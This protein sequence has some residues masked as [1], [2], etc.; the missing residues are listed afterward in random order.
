MP[1]HAVEVLGA[2]EAKAAPG[3]RQVIP[4]AYVVLIPP[5]NPVVSVGPII[6]IPAIRDALRSTAAP[7]VGVSPIL[8]G[9]AVRGM[10]N[11][12]LGGL[13][14]EVSASGVAGFHGG[15]AAEG[16]LDGWLIDHSD[17]DQAPS[18]EQLGIAVGTVPLWMSDPPKTRELAEDA[19]Q[20]AGELGRR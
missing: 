17:A 15:R 16:I 9:S 12:L 14:V 11:Q 3:V 8:G 10:A 6:A 18:I 1:V 4:D 2:E 7:V 13:G 20:L 5:S 19:I